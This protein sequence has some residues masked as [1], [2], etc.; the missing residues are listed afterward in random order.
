MFLPEVARGCL[1]I[2]EHVA[3]PS[4]VANCS[5]AV[6]RCRLDTSGPNLEVWWTFHGENASKLP[7]VV[8]VPP[9]SRNATSLGNLTSPV[10]T[11]PATTATT[12][13]ASTSTAATGANATQTTPAPQ[14][15]SSPVTSTAGASLDDVTTASDDVVDNAAATT[16]VSPAA[17]STTV[18]SPGGSESADEEAADD[19]SV[20]TLRLNC[21]TLE[22]AGSYACYALSR[23]AS[24]F[25]YKKEAL[26]DVYAGYSQAITLPPR[27]NEDEDGGV[28]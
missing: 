19:E 6:L 3:E 13:A 24:E 21:P 20:W 25:I 11:T 14:S 5:A 23:N 22:H 4:L 2:L 26:L 7:N 17:V 9:P 10:T 1:S 27:E 15:S 12:T 18:S 28:F 8:L 16:T